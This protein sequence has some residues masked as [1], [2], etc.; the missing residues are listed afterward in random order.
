MAVHSVVDNRSDKS[1][2][3]AMCIF[4]DAWHDNAI[5]GEKLA[6]EE[7]VLYLSIANTTITDATKFIM[8]EYPRALVTLYL[9]DVDI[10]S[11]NAI[12]YKTIVE[13]PTRPGHMIGVK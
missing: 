2:V 6:Q 3:N 8:Q 12:D 13:D 1:N 10:N 11:T 4:E 7:Q 9:Y 5:H